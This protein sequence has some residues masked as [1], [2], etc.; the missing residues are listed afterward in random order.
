MWVAGVDGCSAGWL[1]VFR[2][3]NR[4]A[5]H[6]QIF[7]SFAN[8]VAK[9][10]AKIAVDIPI[11]LPETSKRG[12]RWADREAR[13]MLGLDR[14]SSVFPAP[15]RATLKVSSFSEACE[16][17]QRNSDPPKKVSQQAFNIIEKIREV[18]II[19]RQHSSLILNAI[20]R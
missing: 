8:I 7:D 11:G 16:I 17:E 14:Q 13:K 1:A 3:T 20:Q 18:D 19:A 5:P 15:S 2:S 12:G 6:A 10:V 9:G 4:D